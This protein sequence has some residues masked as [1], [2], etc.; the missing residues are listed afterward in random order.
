MPTPNIKPQEIVQKPDI[1]V[2]VTILSPEIQEI[3]APTTDTLIT[4]S[5]TKV[6][7]KNNGQ[8]QKER[9]LLRKK[10][11]GMTRIQDYC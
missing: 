4:V 8:K 3:A 11:V 9:V 7:K 6:P 10:Q 1:I 5:T 2:V